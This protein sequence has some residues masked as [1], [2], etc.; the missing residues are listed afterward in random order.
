MAQKTF[1]PRE[2][3][4]QNAFR[5]G[6]SESVVALYGSTSSLST[7]INGVGTDASGLVQDISLGTGI[8]LEVPSINVGG[9]GFPTVPNDNF[10]TDANGNLQFDDAIGASNFPTDANGVLQFDDAIGGVGSSE[11]NNSGAAFKVR[12]VSAIDVKQSVIFET[13]PTSLTESNTT[14][15]STLD[16]VHMPGNYRVFKNTQ[17]RTFSLSVRLLSRTKS[18]ATTNG[19]YL[20]RLRAWMKPYFGE[21][22]RKDTPN[23]LGA[24]PEVLYLYG[25]TNQQQSR[26]RTQAVFNYHRIPVVIESLGVTYPDNVD[27]ISTN[28]GE[29]IPIL[30]SIDLAL[31]ETHSPLEFYEFSLTKYREGRLEYF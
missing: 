11:D 12:L 28:S 7:A 24:P 17:S 1:D 8:G 2:E 15:Y 22:T 19:M 4:L 31:G 20:Q 25:Y 13:S 21:G 16:P 3:A 9:L 5:S 27:Y 23:L 6:A 30:F 29:P 26:A 14:T 18:E 10:P